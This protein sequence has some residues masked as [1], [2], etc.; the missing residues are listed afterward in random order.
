MAK[1]YGQLSGSGKTNATKTETVSTGIQA[2]VQSYD[3][4]VI[5]W[6]REFDGEVAV[7]VEVSRESSTRGKHVF[8]GTLDEFTKALCGETLSEL[9]GSAE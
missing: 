5:I 1:F 9:Y 4:S 3:G 6:M 8:D 2:S 7:Q